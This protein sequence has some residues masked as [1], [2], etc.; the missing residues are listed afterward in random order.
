M[1][2]DRSLKEYAHIASNTGIISRAILE[3][4]FPEYNV[5][6]ITQFMIHFELCQVMDLSLVYTDMA[7]EGSPSP[8]PGPYFFFSALVCVDRPSSA[9]VP[10]NSF[11]WTMIVRSND[12]FFTPRFLHVLLRRLPFEFALPTVQATPLYLLIQRRCDVWSRGLIWLSEEGVATFDESD[13]RKVFEA[14]QSAS[15]GWRAIGWKL[16][17]TEDQLDAIV[18]E[19]GRHGEMDYYRTMLRRWLDWAPPD[20][21]YPSLQ[22]LT[23]ALLAVGKERQASDLGAV[24]NTCTC[25]TVEASHL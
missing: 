3:K 18:H 12:Q 20:H 19:P 14:T 8:D 25:C 13:H 15:D 24:Y 21:P 1:F 16:G 11:G 17:F 23:S 22:T 6:M 5:D 4:T 7:P 10:C 2:A 9:T